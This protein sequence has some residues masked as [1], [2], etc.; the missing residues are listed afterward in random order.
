MKTIHSLTF[1]AIAAL[2]AACSDDENKSA[3]APHFDVAKSALSRDA[4]PNV[5]DAEKIQLVNDNTAFAVDLHKQ[6]AS[7]APSDNLIYSPHSISTAFAMTYAGAR[8]TTADEMA[9]TLHYGLDQARLHPAFDWLDLQL[10]GRGQNTTGQDGK[11]FRLNVVNSV[12]ADKATSFESPFLDTLA[13]SYGAG[14][15]SV[16]FRDPRQR[17]PH[18]RLCGP[19]DGSHERVILKQEPRRTR[20][21]GFG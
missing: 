7:I 14:R 4:A 16:L 13:V 12:W 9:K 10:S 20:G 6:L 17:D 15:P 21:L 11:P 18:D 2:L 3:N 5:S 19:S 1:V 8:S